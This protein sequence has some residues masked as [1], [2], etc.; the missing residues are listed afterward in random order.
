MAIAA[1]LDIVMRTRTAKAEQGIKR[2][3]A[4]IKGLAKTVAA[5][6]AAFVAYRGALNSFRGIVE[7]ERNLAKSTALVLDL[8]DA[9]KQLLKT[10]ALLKGLDP[11]TA[12]GAADIARGYEFLL[13]IERVSKFATAGSFDLAKATDLATDTLSA[14]GLAAQDTETYLKNLDRVTDA[15]ALAASTANATIEQFA[16]AILNQSAGQLKLFNK[17]IE[18]G[19]AI[20][21]AYANAGVKGTEAGT[22]LAVVLRDL[23]RAATL[24]QG[25]FKAAG[26]AVFDGSNNFRNFA[27][28]L[29][30][31]E[32]ALDGL[33][34]LEKIQKLLALG[35]PFKSLSALSTLLGQSD[36]IREYFEAL[37]EAQGVVDQMAKKTM[38]EFDRAIKVVTAAWTVFTSSIITPVLEGF[39]AT[40]NYIVKSLTTVQ[41]K[42]AAWIV[43]TTTLTPLIA[44]LGPI[45]IS[46]AKAMFLL[47]KG[48]ALV[49]AFT[50]PKGWASL[51]AGAVAAAA[52][53]GVI[54]AQL[55]D[56]NQQVKEFENLQAKQQALA[57]AGKAAAENA[58]GLAGAMDKVNA[59]AAAA[60]AE[61]DRLRGVAEQFIQAQ[62]TPWQRY[63]EVLQQIRKVTVEGLLSDR[64]ARV[65]MT[66]ALQDYVLNL[67]INDIQNPTGARFGSQEAAAKRF[68]ANVKTQIRI[69]QESLRA[70]Q[71][72][73][74][75]LQ[76]IEQ[77][78]ATRPPVAVVPA[79]LGN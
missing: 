75:V 30:D 69:Q 53:I 51:A 16:E 2:T 79:Q 78:F 1:V 70:Q 65:A 54:N 61:T 3:Q 42:I 13:A 33:S 5:G 11:D 57:E 10:Q 17:S 39:A 36:A 12:A 77:D 48:S 6:A 40:L 76:Q 26:I 50:G 15:Y 23:A 67:N 7:L 68:G 62:I 66:K 41:G 49:Q 22:K 45:I 73:L 58:E 52:A 37:K 63:L 64:Q 9:Q 24:N 27:D 43:L 56:V 4:A 8:T 55:Q 44:T 46:V 72:Q 47:A 71:E 74:K 31:V 14:M 29:G 38:P 21:A 18:E 20:L 32:T 59:S 35:I 34:D 60:A 28:V 25:A 19:L